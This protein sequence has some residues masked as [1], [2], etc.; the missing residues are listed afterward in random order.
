MNANIAV[1][2]GHPDSRSYCQALSEAYKKGAIDSGATVRGIHIGS[3]SFDPNL[4]FGYHQRVALEDDLIEAQEI[5]KWADHLVFVYPIWWGSVPALMKG[6]IDRTF[7]PGFAFRSRPNSS[8]WDKLLVG[9]SARLIVTMDSPSWYNRLIYR[10]AGHRVMKRATL[11]YCGVNPVKIT[12][13]CPIR[14]STDKKRE[15]WLE[16]VETLG[17]KR[18]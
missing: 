5:I 10:Q 14:S 3:L 13:L 16:E 8:L 1:I 4:R 6:F 12:E 17:R 18:L 2:N 15:Q 7:L 11:Q 9:K